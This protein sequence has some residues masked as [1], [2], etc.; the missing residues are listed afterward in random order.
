MPCALMCIMNYELLLCRSVTD[1]YIYIYIYTHR[2]SLV[3]N[4]EPC[5]KALGNNYIYIY[6]YQVPDNKETSGETDALSS[7]VDSVDTICAAVARHEPQRV[8][9][10]VETSCEAGVL[11]SA[12]GKNSPLK[13]SVC[14]SPS[15]SSHPPNAS[16]KST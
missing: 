12:I 6:L 11:S 1:I 10:N 13:G 16:E 4:H 8:L 3:R 14:S 15:T 7:A 9:D 2:E 5:A